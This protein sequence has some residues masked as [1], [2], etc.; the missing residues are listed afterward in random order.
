A[1]V[2]TTAAAQA[3]PAVERLDRIV[4]VVDEDVLLQS[5][6][7]RA[8]DNILAQSQ[9]AVNL[10]PRDIVEKQV[11]DRLIL[12][13]VQVARAEGTGIQV[14]DADVDQAVARIAEQ[15]KISLEQLRQ[16][17][18]HDGFSFEEFRKTMRDEITVQ[19]FRQRFVQSRVQVTE[20]EIDI[21]L[22]SDSL[23]TGE[24]RLSHILIGVRDGATAAQIET[25]RARADSVVKEINDGLSFAQ[26]AI[27]YSEGQQALEGGDLGWRKYEEVPSAFADLVAGMKKGEVA[28]P[29]R[30]PSGFHILKLVDQRSD[31]SA[32]MVTEFQARHILIQPSELM[33]DAAAEERIKKLRELAVAGAD[34]AELAK[35]N[36]QDTNTANLG[37]DL[38][39]F[40]LTDYGPTVAQA[41]QALKDG[42]ISAPFRTELG[43]HIMKRE[44][45]REVDR[46]KEYI[47]NQA[48]ETIVRRKAEE[49]YDNYLR[50]IRAEAY[51]ENRLAP[52]AG[53]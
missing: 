5:E 49:E 46:T 23:K 16:S 25:A 30:G 36:S 21:A 11:L 22:A 8:V 29:L 26:A 39:W 12:T 45:I 28:Q 50:Q 20:T 42:E 9:S 52:V 38:G 4:A 41:V 2:A 43:W 24:V 47:R 13:R 18:E 17:L 35:K 44:G 48:R 32:K 53:S 7:D 6:L 14:N 40:T 3:M 31:D 10:P 34:F 51:V 37:G 19:R 15:N 27:K 1:S 33:T